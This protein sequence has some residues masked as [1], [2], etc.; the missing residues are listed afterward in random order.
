MVLPIPRLEPAARLVERA[1]LHRHA[2]ADSD[3]R[4]QRALVEGQRPLVHVDLA[5]RIERAAVRARRLQ[6][7]LDYVWMAKGVRG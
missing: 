4:R 1:E 3:Q 2:R 6:P 5:R 7:D